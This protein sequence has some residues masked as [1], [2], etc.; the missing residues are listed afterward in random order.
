MEIKGKVSSISSDGVRIIVDNSENKVTSPFKV[1]A[2]VG[3]LEAGDNVAA[4]VF[5]DNM[6]DGLII[7]KYSEV[8]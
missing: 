1:A 2:H 5:S 7:A 4:I 6:A 3:V 8:V